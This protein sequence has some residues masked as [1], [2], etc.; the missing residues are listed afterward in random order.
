MTQTYMTSKEGWHALSRH[1]PVCQRERQISAGLP[2]LAARVL[3]QVQMHSKR[4]M[5]LPL[6]HTAAATCLKRQQQQH[7]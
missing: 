6:H 4:H 5:A 2:S 7:M 3:Q 1:R